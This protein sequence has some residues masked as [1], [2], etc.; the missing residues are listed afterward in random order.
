MRR[1]SPI[2]LSERW[3]VRY[4]GKGSGVTRIRDW[5]LVTT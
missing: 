3:E 1:E 4:N 5:D 2:W